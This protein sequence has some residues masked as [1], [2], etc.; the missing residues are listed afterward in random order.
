MTTISFDNIGAQRIAQ[1]TE[2]MFAARSH[3][4]HGVLRDEIQRNLS[5][6]T[7]SFTI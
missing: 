5:S 4:V 1:Q 7:Q 3:I 2:Q 6:S